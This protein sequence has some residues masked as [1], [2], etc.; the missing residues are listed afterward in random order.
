VSQLDAT[1]EILANHTSQNFPFLD[2]SGNDRNRV[3]FYT[4]LSKLLYMKTD[5][6]SNSDN[7][8]SPVSLYVYLYFQLFLMFS[9]VSIDCNV[10]RIRFAILNQ[11]VNV[12]TTSE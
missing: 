2:V 12:T 7:S 8:A 11:F 1:N 5:G 9:C 4:T 6:V 3:R 10:F